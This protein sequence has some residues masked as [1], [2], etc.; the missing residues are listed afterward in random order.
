[1]TR[2]QYS[3]WPVERLLCELGEST[4]EFSEILAKFVDDRRSY[5]RMFSTL[6]L[7]QTLGVSTCVRT[8]KAEEPFLFT[9][10]EFVG[11]E[12]SRKLQEFFDFL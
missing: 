5:V 1:M 10:D 8:N 11:S 2:N 7:A 9:E 3:V 4:I 6:R 12:L